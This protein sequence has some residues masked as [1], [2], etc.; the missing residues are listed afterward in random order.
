MVYKYN[1]N[2][3]TGDYG[4]KSNLEYAI[5]PTDHIVVSS[6]VLRKSLVKM[7]QD[8]NK[9]V[10]VYSA[11]DQIEDKQYFAWL[12]DYGVD[13][14]ITSQPELSPSYLQKHM[15]AA[16][17]GIF[18]FL[19]IT[20]CCMSIFYTIYK[21]YEFKFNFELNQNNMVKEREDRN[22]TVRKFNYTAINES[23]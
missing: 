2:E 15:T 20:C 19:C 12:E 1:E 3:G 16:S 17:N 21:K 7:C 10:G 18:L 13:F 11:A 23:N 4:D 5:A 14:V 6:S 8:H 22:T 9:T